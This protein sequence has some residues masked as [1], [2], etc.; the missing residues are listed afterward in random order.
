M[1][2]NYYS[3]RMHASRL[4]RHVSGA[5]RIVSGEKIDKTVS[6]LVSRGM[7]KGCTPDRVSITIDDLGNVRPRALKALDVITINAPDSFKGMAIAS[8]ILKRA[9]VADL[10]ANQAVNFLK[11]GAAPS[12]GNMRGAM[13]M[14]C[15]TGKRLEPDPER[16][17]RASRFDWRE[18]AS[19]RI[20]KM[21]AD[22]GLSHFR[23]YEALALATKI[24]HGP[25]VKAELCW[26][27]DPDYTAGYVASLTTGYV[28]FPVLKE[29]G[30]NKGGRAIFVDPAVLNLDLLIHYLQNEAILISGIGTCTTASAADC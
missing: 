4:N 9:G 10:A 24:A 25:G 28:R 27:D 23:T 14:D 20:K 19:S 17:I 26:S 18:E 16:G 5:E 15:K 22:N 3:I 30:D 7:G 2:N 11:K 1:N 13:I 21:L 29:K 6:E 8:L 12:T